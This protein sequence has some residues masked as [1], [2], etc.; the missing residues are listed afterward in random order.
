MRRRGRGEGFI[1]CPVADISLIGIWTKNAKSNTNTLAAGLGGI[2]G[3]PVNTIKR[4]AYSCAKIRQKVS[5]SF[6]FQALAPVARS[7]IAF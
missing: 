1:R 3:P 5:G 4:K 6:S 7:P 2:P